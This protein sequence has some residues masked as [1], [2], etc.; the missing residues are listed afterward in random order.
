[1]E[2]ISTRQLSE[3]VELVQSTPLG[4]SKEVSYPPGTEGKILVSRIPSEEETQENII[5]IL[6]VKKNIVIALIESDRG[7]FFS[8]ELSKA[9][10][11]RFNR[12]ASHDKAASKG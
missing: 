12:E 10:S 2:I 4:G 9:L 1:M 11:E 5:T 7:I 8:K 6:G 3:L